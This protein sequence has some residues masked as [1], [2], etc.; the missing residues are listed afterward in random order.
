MVGKIFPKIDLSDA[1]LQ[2]QVEEV[3]SKLLCVNTHRGLYK[4]E[5][6]PF[7]VKNTPA[8]FQQVMDIMLR[9]FDFAVIYLDD[10]LINS[11]SVVEHKD[12]VHKVFAKINDNGF[13]IKET[14]CDFFHGKN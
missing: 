2:I 10:V 13:K 3:Y 1:Y 9:G 11:K 12:H 8:I 5:L 7:G 14:K 6:L 4:F